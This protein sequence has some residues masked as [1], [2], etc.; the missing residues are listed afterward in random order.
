MVRSTPW[1]PNDRTASDAIPM[2]LRSVSLLLRKPLAE[3]II[4]LLSLPEIMP[5]AAAKPRI[6]VGPD[7]GIDTFQTIMAAVVT[8]RP[9]TDGS[10]RQREVIEHH[11]QFGRLHL[12]FPEPVPHCIA[13]V[14]HIGGWLEQEEGT[15]L[16]SH[17]RHIAV[18]LRP[19]NS[20]G[21]RSEGIQH[22]KTYIVPGFGIFGAYVPESGY[23]IL[24][25]LPV[26]FLL[27]CGGSGGGTACGTRHDDSA[28]RS[29]RRGKQRQ[30]VVFQVA[31]ENRL[32]DTEIRD[33]DFEE[34]GQVLYQT[35]DA[36]FA[37][38]YGRL[39]PSF[40]PSELP[41]I[42]TGT[43]IATGLPGS[44]RKKSTCMG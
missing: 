13:A 8:L 10:Q 28:Y 2:T 15:P 18:T 39:P 12:F 16:E 31:H 9:H 42:F 1:V 11:Q 25:E 43:S 40:T 32:A 35:A 17:L 37:F 4:H 30:V 3:H 6:G 27:A 20:V 23:Q 21:C 29:G 26:L 36:Q 22:F 38:L 24:H 34:I 41:T 14:I 7:A 44:T 33:I 5:Y 19:E